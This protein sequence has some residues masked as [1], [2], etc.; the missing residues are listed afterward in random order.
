MGFFSSLFGR[1]DDDGEYEEEEL[2]ALPDIYRGM[3]LIVETTD[4]QQVLSGQV[5]EFDGGGRELTLERLPG[6]LSFKT[7]ELGSSVMIRGIDESLIQ[8]YLKGTVAE[9]TRMAFR[10]KDVQ[11]REVP[12]NR[13]NFRLE[14]SAP[15]TMYGQVGEELYGPPE[16]CTLVDIS[17]GGACVESEY[18]HAEDD[19]LR[20]KIKLLDYSPMEFIGEV[21]RV[22]EPKPGRFRYGI[23]F[24]QLKEK[25]LA[26]LTRTLYN[27]QAGNRS[28]W[29][30]SADGHWNS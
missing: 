7:R 21:I 13:Q 2:G 3:T 5:A 9:S 26:E 18:V 8:F 16:E 20:I 19:V 10:V 28:T 11:V 27:I 23:L 22:S 29:M 12:K 6:G 25:E 17:I 24:A 14:L 15:V 4:G 1:S 30:R